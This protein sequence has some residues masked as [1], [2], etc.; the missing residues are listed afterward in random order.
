MLDAVWKEHLYALDH[1]RQGIGLRAYG[2]RDPLNEYKSEAFA[3]FNAMLDEL[4]ERVTAMLARVEVQPEQPPEPQFQ[5]RPQAMFELH[6][7]PEPM[8]AGAPAPEMAMEA[9]AP[10]QVLAQPVRSGAVDPD[11]PATWRNTPRNAACPCG[12]GRKFKHCHGRLA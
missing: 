1:L 8:L 10:V 2:Q 3:L 11:D 9:A 5:P 6:P 4:K 7:E 12:S